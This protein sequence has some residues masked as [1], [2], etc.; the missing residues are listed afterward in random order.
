MD[1]L[2]LNDNDIGLYLEEIPDDFGLTDIESDE[3]NEPIYTTNFDRIFQGQLSLSG[4]L[5]V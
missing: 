5:T 4:K 3:D 2:P 1:K